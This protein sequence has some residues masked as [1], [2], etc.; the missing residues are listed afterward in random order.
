MWRSEVNPEEV[1]LFFHQWTW[2]GAGQTGVIR[3]ARQVLSPAE[4][5]EW[6][7]ISCFK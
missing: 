2:W 7:S 6:P 5:S 4:P 1:V 3:F